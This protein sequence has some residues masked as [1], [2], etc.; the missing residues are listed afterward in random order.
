MTTVNFDPQSGAIMRNGKVNTI[1]GTPK[2]GMDLVRYELF[3]MGNIPLGKAQQP[4]VYP[5]NIRFITKIP[6]GEPLKLVTQTFPSLTIY[7]VDSPPTRAVVY[8]NAA[9]VSNFCY[10]NDPAKIIK[11]I[12]GGSII[13]EPS[14]LTASAPSSGT[15]T[16]QVEGGEPSLM[17]NSSKILFAFL[18]IVFAVTT[19]MIK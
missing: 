17:E 10:V 5:I 15:S 11:L 4:N 16:Y 13:G 18:I 14:A 12:P 6:I 1:F 7:D 3:V 8:T 19:A 9:G 2:D